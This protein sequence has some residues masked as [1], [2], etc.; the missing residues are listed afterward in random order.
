MRHQIIC[1]IAALLLLSTCRPQNQVRTIPM[2]HDPQAKFAAFANDA[3]FRAA[4]TASRSAVPTQQGSM[5]EWP[6]AGGAAGRGYMVKAGKNKRKYLLLFH[7]W[8]GLNDNIKNEADYW[9]ETLKMNVLAIDLYDGQLTTNPDQA[10]KLMQGNDVARSLSIIRGATAFCGAN[11]NFR[12]MG[13]CFGGGWSL[14]ASLLLGKAAK[15][16]V[17]YYGMPEQDVARL[18]N[19][20]TNVLF[21]HASKDKWINDKVVADFETNMASANK[22]VTVHRYDADHAFA[23]PTGARYNEAAAKAARDVVIEYLK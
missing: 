21:I 13:W 8:W 10:G 5:V 20:N 23:N 14:K 2:C 19:L 16:C 15:G 3:T 17:M 18:K 12:T 22:K 6:V 7:E 4:H 11:A 1:S 9:A